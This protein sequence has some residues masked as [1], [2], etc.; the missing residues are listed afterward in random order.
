MRR[1]V[2]S[3]R[4]KHKISA[5]PHGPSETVPYRCRCMIFRAVLT[6]HATFHNRV[7]TP[8]SLHFNVSY[9]RITTFYSSTLR[10]I[11]FFLLVVTLL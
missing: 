11:W 4:L 9:I 1:Q 2:S 8:S 6:Q 5:P 7:D 10:H 3:A